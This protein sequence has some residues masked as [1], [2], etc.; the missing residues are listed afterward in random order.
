MAEKPIPL[1]VDNT[2]RW[3]LV[4]R[5]GD[6][7]VPERGPVAYDGDADNV[8]ANATAVS[9]GTGDVFVGATATTRGSG[10]ASAENQA[11][12]FGGG[13]AT[14]TAFASTAG[15]DGGAHAGPSAY[16]DGAGDSDAGPSASADGSGNAFAGASADNGGTGDSSVFDS[17]TGNAGSGTMTSGFRSVRDSVGVTVVATASASGLSLETTYGAL[18]WQS[19][20]GTD[21]PS[22][23]AG[24]PAPILSTYRRDNA[25]TGELW[26]KTG[27]AD[28]DWTQVV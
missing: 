26:F 4:G 27:A 15:A 17:A 16:T 7:P 10:A 11:F 13:D 23:G 9:D 6:F 12:A 21:D 18:T 28:T 19:I 5:V 20:A 24:I 14:V 8:Y 1:I 2:V 22:A 3:R 25:G